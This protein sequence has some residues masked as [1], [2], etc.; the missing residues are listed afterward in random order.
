MLE[1]RLAPGQHAIVVDA[2]RS[3]VYLYENRLGTL[4]PV[5]DYYSAI[6]KLGTAKEREGDK[7]TPIGI[8]HVSS[9][10]PGGRLPDLYGW[11][12]FP[13][14]Y[15]NGWD[16]R[17]GR[18]GN[19]IWIHGVPPVTYARGPLS[20]DGC[21]AL[22][23]PEIADLAQRVQPGIT[24]VVIADSSD[25]PRA[26]WP[27]LTAAASRRVT[28]TVRNDPSAPC[29]PSSIVSPARAWSAAR[30]DSSSNALK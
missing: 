8:Y 28:S 3:R 19:G 23:N 12:A 29:R 24:P 7:R 30:S 10:I 27:A 9:H 13:I 6:G 14:S 17:L 26:P 22:A 15:P 4:R 5:R 2:S 25:T 1:W 18:T 20:T 11:G 16:R 21:V